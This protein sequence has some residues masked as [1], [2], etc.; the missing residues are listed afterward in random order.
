MKQSTMRNLAFL[1][2]PTLLLAATGCVS[3]ALPLYPPA[4]DV[5]ATTEPKPVPTAE[6]VTDAQ[7]NARYNAEVEGWGE[8]LQAAGVR[9]CLWLNE[10]GAQY[11]CGP[12]SGQ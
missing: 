4:A 6:I 10:A 7:A 1:T 8:R 12:P 11:D 9:L 2:L 5:E 3:Q